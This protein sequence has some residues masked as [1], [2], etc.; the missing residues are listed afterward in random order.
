MLFSVLDNV[1]RVEDT[2]EANEGK[3]DDDQPAKSFSLGQN[4]DKHKFDGVHQRV[5][6]VLK[7]SKTCVSGELANC[8]LIA[9][10]AKNPFSTIH[11]FLA[12]R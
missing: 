11:I 9:T 5:Q 12:L 4:N 7:T 10:G 6:A 1:G 3:G 8:A 2:S